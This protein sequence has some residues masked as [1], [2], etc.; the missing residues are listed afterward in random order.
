MLCLLKPRLSV[1][2]PVYNGDKYIGEAIESILAQSFLDYELIIIDDASMDDTAKC[3]M[4]FND[5][6]IRYVRNDENIGVAGSLNRGMGMANGEYIARMDADDICR[7]S[8]LRQ[9]VDFMDAHPDVAVCG[10]W[11]R[12]RGAYANPVLRKPYVGAAATVF[13]FLDNPLIHPTVM[14]RASVL[15][16]HHLR[17]DSTFSRSE[18]YDLWCR[19]ARF[20]GIANI[21]E[22]LLD[23]SVH[24]G[25]VTSTTS[26]EMEKQ[27]RMIVRREL[28]GVGW[29]LSDEELDFYR[30]VGHGSAMDSQADLARAEQLIVKFSTFDWRVIGVGMGDAHH[31]ASFAW[32]GC[33][34]ASAKLGIAA[35]SKWRHSRLAPYYAPPKEDVIRMIAGVIISTIWKKKYL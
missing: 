11:A 9:Q 13:R 7:P 33:C 22:V 19:L 18:D 10:T 1:L 15:K 24:P 8:R 3:V 16:D 20:G 30:R 14:M 35:W 28:H 17:Y 31:A 26:E 12:I 6:R 5:K 21:P 4:Q 34:A 23:Y 27:T 25:S 32:F 2:M 29:D